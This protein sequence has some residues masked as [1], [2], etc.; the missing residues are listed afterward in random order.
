MYIVV[1]WYIYICSFQLIC[2]LLNSV[3]DSFSRMKLAQWIRHS[4]AVLAASQGGKHPQ[5]E[6][7]VSTV[8]FNRGLRRIAAKEGL[9]MGANLWKF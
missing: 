3:F 2:G 5:L 9:K 4:S 8:S 6:L 7:D 1:L